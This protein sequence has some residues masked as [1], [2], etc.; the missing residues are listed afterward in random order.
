MIRY[1]MI[2]KVLYTLLHHTHIFILTITNDDD[3]GGA[4]KARR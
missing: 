3:D 4:T 2:T 1:G